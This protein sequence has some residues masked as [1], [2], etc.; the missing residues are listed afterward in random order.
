V[1][2]LTR[3]VSR[4]NPQA[5]SN[6]LLALNQMGVSWQG[7]TS[8]QLDGLFMQALK[9]NVS[10]FNPQNTSNSLLA[11]NQMGVNWQGLKSVQL[12]GLFVQALTRNVSRFNPQE[13]SNS[14]LALNQMGVNWQGL[15]SLQLAGLFVQALTRNVSRFNPQA[16]SNSL[17]ALN[18]MGV[19]W[20]GLTSVQLDGLFV[21]ALTRNVSRFNP[22]EI[23]NS[24]LAL[25]QMGVSW[26]G[27]TS[28][29]LAGLFVQALKRNVSGFNP[30]GTSN[31]LL[32]LSRMQC[33]DNITFCL[34]KLAK[35]F[36]ASG[37]L[38]VCEQQQLAQAEVHLGVM[39]SLKLPLMMVN[40]SKL[41]KSVT[42]QLKQLYPKANV[43]K[44][45][46]CLNAYS[47][48]ILINDILVIEVNGPHHFLFSGER[49]A[50]D[51]QKEALFKERGYQY[52]NIDY[53]DWR[54]EPEEQKRLLK[55]KMAG[56]ILEKKS[57]RLNADAPNFVPSYINSV[58]KTAQELQVDGHTKQRCTQ[59]TSKGGPVF[60]VGY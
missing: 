7:L 48:D 5:T 43:K 16:T 25:N 15:T 52:V 44:E 1:Q 58:N 56:T 29:Q 28:L 55:D 60:G 2:A 3:N 30:Q 23:S 37:M 11:L 47:V 14:L 50:T 18:Q 13:T 40:S 33:R 31:S 21:Q 45:A 57:M 51:L 12:A 59:K 10:R 53:F 34:L 22:Q 26:Q 9:R 38:G 35:T 49:K 8:V 32:A 17:L 27:L 4:F 39:P 54:I 46:L 36:Y 41:Q 42:S 20:Q 24:L 6:S 19:S